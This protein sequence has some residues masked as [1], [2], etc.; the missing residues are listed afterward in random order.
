VPTEGGWYG[1]RWMAGKSRDQAESPHK[2]VE[3]RDRFKVWMRNS[4]TGT[5]KLSRGMLP[6]TQRP[7]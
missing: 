7:G 3:T 2:S 5:E 6:C 4:S 1:F